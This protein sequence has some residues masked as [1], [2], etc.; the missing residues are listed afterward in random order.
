M[1]SGHSCKKHISTWINFIGFKKKRKKDLIP[2]SN[3][4]LLSLPIVIFDIHTWRGPGDTL[5][6]VKTENNEVDWLSS[7]DNANTLFPLRI[8]LRTF[9]V[10][11]RRDNHYTMETCS[12]NTILPI[13]NL[14][15]NTYLFILIFKIQWNK[16]CTLLPS[17][18]NFFANSYERTHQH[19]AFFNT[20]SCKQQIIHK[21]SFTLFLINWFPLILDFKYV[22]SCTDH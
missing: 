3:N 9:S 20:I 1:I 14:C 17:E 7:N 18:T 10:L 15:I 19:I 12:C 16:K 21:L 22:E 5:F 13:R 8:E 11:G 6:H 2:Y 4:G